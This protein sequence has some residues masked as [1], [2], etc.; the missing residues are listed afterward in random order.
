MCIH[1]HTYIRTLLA[2]LCYA[3]ISSYMYI[4]ARHMQHACNA[5][6]VVIKCSSI[7]AT[8]RFK[9]I[10]FIIVYNIYYSIS[11]S[12]MMWATVLHTYIHLKLS[13]NVRKCGIAIIKLRFVVVS[14]KNVM[15]Y[16]STKTPKAKLSRIWRNCL[17]LTEIF[18]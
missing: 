8:S 5:K 16:S 9:L 17:N 7:R 2:M 13:T 6:N 3:C 10:R 18:R 12:T 14:N 15:Y 11:R 4:H 1:I